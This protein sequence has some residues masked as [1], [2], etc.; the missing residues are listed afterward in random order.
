MSFFFQK[1]YFG[2]LGVFVE[3]LFYFLVMT[4]IVRVCVCVFERIK[5]KKERKESHL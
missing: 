5:K 2:V 4:E 3:F 1:F